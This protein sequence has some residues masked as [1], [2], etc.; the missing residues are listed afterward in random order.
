MF[1]HKS[2]YLFGDA[3]KLWWIFIIAGIFALMSSYLIELNV[4]HSR[5]I[6][7]GSVTIFIGLTL[8]LNYFGLQ[9]DTANKL[10][11]NFTAVFGIKTGAW[12]PLPKLQKVI[13]TSRNVSFWN[14]PNG[15]SPTFKSNSTIY[16]IALFSN[17]ENPDFFIQ[18][19]HK[20]KAKQKTKILSDLLMIPFEELFTN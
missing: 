16:T 9:I 10:I 14:T 4:S 13:L 5:I 17:G 2:G 15:I 18:T 1:I 11:R 7:I 8:K 20:K 6:I 12:N 3:S 19:E